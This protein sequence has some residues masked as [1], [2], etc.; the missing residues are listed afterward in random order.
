MTAVPHPIPYQGSKR[1]LAPIILGHLPAAAGTLFEPFAGSAAVSL[2]AL[3]AGRVTA[4]H[5]NDSLAPLAGLWRAIV[6]DPAAVADRYEAL[7]RAQL[8]DPRAHYDAVRRRYNRAPDPARLLYLLARCVKNAVRFNAGGAF[9]QSPDA[10]RLG[11]RP[12]RMRANLAGASA[13]LRGRATITAD[14]YA[15]ILAR[16]TPRDI[17]YMDPPYQ[18]TSGDR[19]QRYHAQLDLGRFVDDVAAL[20]RRRVPMI[21]SLDGRCG[22]R[23]YGQTLPAQLGLVRLEVAAGRSSQATL[24]GRADETVESLYVSPA[25]LSARAAAAATPPPRSRRRSAASPPPRPARPAPTSS[26]HPSS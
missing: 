23:S 14:D 2:A 7:W 16:A 17:V 15:A 6:D 18:G 11:V 5:L 25:L 4:V 19:D 24:H 8:A 1:K 9:N 22:D 3:H 20:A 10:R 13:L 12:P 21:I 26:R